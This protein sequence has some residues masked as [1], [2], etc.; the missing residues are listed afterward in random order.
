MVHVPVLT[1]VGKYAAGA[2]GFVVGRHYGDIVKK[3]RELLGSAPAVKTTTTT[4]TARPMI[5]RNNSN[6]NKQLLRIEQEMSVTNKSH[7]GRSRRSFAA[8]GKFAAKYAAWLAVMV[9]AG[10]TSSAAEQ[11]F[12]NHFE[13]KRI[14]K[15]RR[16]T[17]D[18]NTNE[19]GCLNGRCWTQCG[20][21][22]NTIDW[23]ITSY[24]HKYE[25]VTKFDFIMNA[26]VIRKQYLPAVC[27]VN[28]DC[29]PC[30][31]CTK[32]CHGDE[33][34]SPLQFS[35]EIKDEP[36][37][38]KKMMNVDKNIHLSMRDFP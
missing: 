4:T 3:A 10:V 11:F 31:R 34:F 13:E 32:G 2:V 16:L 23:C 21:R 14:E 24:G 35:N 7:V 38:K 33:T 22:S 25:N 15:L 29:G 18:C 19:F 28:E 1:Q 12:A 36:D 6:I 27:E 37:F 9:S 5:P 20:P 17:F 8:V 30:L 26:T